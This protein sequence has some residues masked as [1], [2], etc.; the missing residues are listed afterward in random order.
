M[1]PAAALR[2]EQ[3]ININGQALTLSSRRGLPA[4]FA[5]FNRDIV[6]VACAD[7]RGQFGGSLPGHV[8]YFDERLVRV[9]PAEP[10]SSLGI[11]SINSEG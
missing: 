8:F 9:G 6:T 5:T 4:P 3:G 1:K 11:Y 7:Q 10:L 2:S